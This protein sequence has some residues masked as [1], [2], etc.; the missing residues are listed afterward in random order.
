MS[1]PPP[2]KIESA[3]PP[4]SIESPKVDPAK[5]TIVSAADVPI[6]V[7]APVDVISM[8]SKPET[9]WPET[10]TES[11]ARTM[12]VSMPSPPSIVVAPL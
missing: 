10:F 11:P 7:V 2:A 1:L 5:S 4:P 8:I 3:P 6:T 12:S 9:F